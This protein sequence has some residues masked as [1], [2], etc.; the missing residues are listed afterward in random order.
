MRHFAMTG[1][2][3]APWIS[4]ILVGSAMRATPPAARMSA[5]TRSSAITA[6]APADS[7]IR[8]WSAVTTSMI[9]PPLSISARPAL[10]RNVAVSF[11]GPII[12][13][14]RAYLAAPLL[15]P[16]GLDAIGVGRLVE[17]VDAVRERL[18]QRQE[19]GV[20]ADERRAVRRVVQPLVGELRD[21]RQ[22]RVRDRDGVRAP[23]AGELHRAHDERVRAPGGE[24]DHER[25]VVD[26]AE[27]RKP[28]LARAR[29]DLAAEVEQHQQVPQVAREE[30]H[31][32]GAAQERV[33]GA[34]D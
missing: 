15:Q 11:T 33:L 12:R 4:S 18:D 29:H 28:L 22:R 7:A 32:V 17:R 14:R 26:P 10:T 13:T 20:R 31:L 16:E 2:V 9:T 21:L 5:G 8:A 25:A 6:T 24:A 23:V 1:I 19:R 27:P 3:T 30:R 34:R